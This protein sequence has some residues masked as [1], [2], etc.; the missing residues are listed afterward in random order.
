MPL[1]IFHGREDRNCPFAVTQEL[2][3]KLERSGARVTLVTEEGAG[4]Q[5]PGP[6]ALRRYH[7]WLRKIV[8]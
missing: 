5:R 2:V 8:G 4:H 7:E 1:F 6:E 3:R